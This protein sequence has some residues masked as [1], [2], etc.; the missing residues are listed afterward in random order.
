M[1][2]EANALAEN[3]GVVFEK[4]YFEILFE[5]VAE[6]IVVADI[7]GIVL[8]ING[9]FTRMFGYTSQEVVGQPLDELIAPPNLTEEAVIITQTVSMGNPFSLET[10]RRRKSGELFQVSLIGAPIIC[11]GKQVASFGIYRDI[12]GPKKVEEDLRQEK[13]FLQQLV[14]SAPE[15]IVLVDNDGRILR[16][17]NAFFRLFGYTEKEVAGKNID[18]LVAPADK[19]DEAT[20]ITD[21]V[22]MG[23]PFC[24]ETMRRHKDGHLIHVSLIGSPIIIDGQQVASYGIYRDITDRKLAEEAFQKERTYLEQLVETAPEGIVMI[25][26]SGRIVR[27]NGEFSRLFGYNAKEAVG[28]NIDDLIIPPDRRGEGAQLTQ[29]V[30]K[31]KHFSIE[32]VRRRKDNGLIHVSIIGSPIVIG[33]QQMATYGIYRD[34]SER[35]RIESQR[36]ATLEDLLAS[37]AEKEVLLKEIHHRVKNNLMSIIGLIQLQSMKAKN[38]TLSALLQGIEGRIRSMAL[39]HDNLYQSKDL[40]CIGFKNY[41]EKLIDQ[42]IA[43]LNPSRDIHCQVQMADIEVDLDFAIP[44]GLIVNELLTNAFKYA[45]PGGKPRSG[46]PACTI[47]VCMEQNDTTWALVIADNGVGLPAALKEG[48]SESLGLKLVKMLVKQLSGTI[49]VDRTAGTMFR[50]VFPIQ[51]KKK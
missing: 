23:E 1:S 13:A 35:K 50:L 18:A 24:L 14:D 43:S 36:D 4:A 6:A 40:A 28:R 45:F 30:I 2:S 49:K 25:D 31:G 17:N 48:T 27:I 39:V 5:R 29:A 15:A 47:K 8:R 21:L 34:I 46:E 41:L 51:S 12:S 10:V 44:C 32:T 37:L 16:I 19:M 42:I 3:K 9:E 26:M 7:G 22:N 11:D 20:S 38:E 33:N